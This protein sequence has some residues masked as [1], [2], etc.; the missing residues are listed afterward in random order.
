M[1]FLKKEWKTISLI[2]CLIVIVVYMSRINS[3]LET[4]KNQNVKLVSTIGSVESVALSTD[5][6]INDMGK[7]VNSIETGVSFTVQKLRRR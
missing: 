6:S 2:L 4:L 3:Q 7:K 5:A 1:G